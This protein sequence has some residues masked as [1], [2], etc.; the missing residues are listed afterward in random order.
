MASLSRSRDQAGPRPDRSESATGVGLGYVIAAAPT[1]LALYN[2]LM[3][4]NGDQATLVALLRS[5]DPVTL[6]LGLLA[7]YVPLLVQL[8][9]GQWLVAEAHRDPT[10]RAVVPLVVYLCAAGLGVVSAPFNLRVLVPVLLL[11]IDLT[12]YALGTRRDVRLPTR[13]FR[14]ALTSVLLFEL[15]AFFIRPG[16]YWLPSEVIQTRIETLSGIDSQVRATYVVSTDD[17]YTTVLWMRS[18]T[19]DG[20]A[21]LPHDQRGVVNVRNEEIAQRV[22]CSEA[23]GPRPLSSFFLR[24]D[25][26]TPSCR[27]LV[28]RL[29]QAGSR[30]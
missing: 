11:V 23:T 29:R 12:M 2:L 22:P 25:Y 6:L 17:Q 24:P 13:R 9:A 15:L 27:S 26:R 30:N 28:A 18:G 8:V 1:L 20:E 14:G 7:P 21:A 3:L 4:S 19:G 16:P 10:G 5:S